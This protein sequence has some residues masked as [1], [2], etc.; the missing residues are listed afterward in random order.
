[1]DDGRCKI[2]DGKA[3]LDNVVKDNWN[4]I[5]KNRRAVDNDD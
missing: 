5:K 3:S 1:M 2:E 4:Q